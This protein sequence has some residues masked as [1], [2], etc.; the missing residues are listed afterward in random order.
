MPRIFWPDKPRGHIS[1]YT[2]SIYYGLQD[3]DATR[4]TT[5]AFG[6]LPEAYANF[7]FVGIAAFGVIAGLGFRK[8]MQW[9]A[10]A[11]VFSHAGLMLIL[12]TAWS[13]QTELTLSGWIA[14]LFQAAI[15][16][17]VAVFAFR[18]FQGISA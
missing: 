9:S 13:F 2:L 4:E 1:T 15:A 17:L 12:V 6:F 11:P 14:S 5:I 10:Q 7:G 8:L 16:I 18:R 3:E